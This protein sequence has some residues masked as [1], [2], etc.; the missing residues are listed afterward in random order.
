MTR[1]LPSLLALAVSLAWGCGSAETPQPE[2]PFDAGGDVSPPDADPPAPRAACANVA[3]TAACK[4]SG[5]YDLTYEQVTIEST[6][7]T[8]GMSCRQVSPRQ[9]VVFTA[10][11][12]LVCADVD[13]LKITDD[14]CTV[15]LTASA[16]TQAASEDWTNE[17]ALKLTFKTQENGRLGAEGTARL[18]LYGF[19]SC[20]ETATVTARAP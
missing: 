14:G 11:A 7:D 4:L 8:S 17:S 10:G 1:T 19:L 9:R 12:G 6:P 18:R 16:H 2:R 5:P 3:A 13:E 15:E 20:T